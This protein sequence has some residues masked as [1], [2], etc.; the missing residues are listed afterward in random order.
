ML[1]LEALGK[2]SAPGLLQL[3]RA[4]RTL[5]LVVH[6]SI[7]EASRVKSSDL[8]LIAPSILT[9]CFLFL[10]LPSSEFSGPS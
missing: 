1:L 6:S 10:L 5:W 4:P 2:N 7:L 8:S 9:S 3:L